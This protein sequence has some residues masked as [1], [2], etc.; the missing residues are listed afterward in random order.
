VIAAIFIGFIPLI[1]LFSGV[2]VVWWPPV[3]C[4][5]MAGFTLIGTILFAVKQLK[6]E[7]TK[8]FHI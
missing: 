5:F 6:N 4:A 1:L 2:I 3:I 8:R 7:M